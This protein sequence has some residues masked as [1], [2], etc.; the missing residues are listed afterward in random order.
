MPF[1]VGNGLLILVPCAVTLADLAAH[2]SF[3]WTFYAVQ[4]LELIAGAANLALIGFNLRDGLRLTGRTRR[5]PA[6]PHRV[7]STH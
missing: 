5:R 6:K 7:P 1:I 2:A 3:G 4:A